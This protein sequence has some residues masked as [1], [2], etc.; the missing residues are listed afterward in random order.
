M[1]IPAFR[2]TL[3]PKPGLLPRFS[4]DAWYKVNRSD[5]SYRQLPLSGSFQNIVFI[6]ES[7]R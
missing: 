6:T 1:K 3:E 7:T 5:D 4:G 2:I